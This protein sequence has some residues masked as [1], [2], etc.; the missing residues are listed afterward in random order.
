MSL[1]SEAAGALNGQSTYGQATHGQ[2]PGREAA[3]G[4]GQ[5]GTQMREQAGGRTA[6]LA[7]GGLT[8]PRMGGQTDARM[9]APTPDMSS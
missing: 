5:R 3:G 4:R 1:P 6:V 7:A 8:S 9:V 2:T